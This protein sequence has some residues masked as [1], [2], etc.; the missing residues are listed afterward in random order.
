MLQMGHAEHEHASPAAAVGQPPKWYAH[1]GI[2]EGKGQ[3]L[4]QTELE[5]VDMKTA[6]DRTNKIENDGSIY[7]GEGVGQVQNGY[8][9]PCIAGSWILR[10]CYD[11]RG[12]QRICKTSHQ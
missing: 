4:N 6:S 8:H 1:R 9:V 7:E 10:R 3:T 2:A 12:R 5:I 11:L